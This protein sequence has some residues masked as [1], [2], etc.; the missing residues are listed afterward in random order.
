MCTFDSS[1]AQGAVA[2]CI[3]SHFENPDDTTRFVFATSVVRSSWVDWA[4]EHVSQAVPLERFL[5]W[6]EFKKEQLHLVEEEGQTI[7]SLLRKIFVQN[8]LA[9]G[10][11]VTGGASVKIGS[12]GAAGGASLTGAAKSSLFPSL[13]PAEVAG[14]PSQA[15]AFSD[16]IA[17]MLP[18]LKLWH[19]KWERAKKADPSLVADESD[20][21]YEKLY[22]L[23]KDFLAG[24]GR[25]GPVFYESAWVDSGKLAEALDGIE[26]DYIIIYPEI[27]DDWDEYRPFIE[28]SSRV[29]A[30]YLPGPDDMSERMLH[31]PVDFYTNARSELRACAVEIRRLCA[32]GDA[33][34]GDASVTGGEDSLP[35][36]AAGLVPWNQIAVSV[37]DLEKWRPYIEREFKLYCIPHVI[38]SAEKLT[39]GA[40]RIFREIQACVSENFS[41]ES[42]RA[43]LLDESLPWKDKQR[44]MFLIRDAL[45][46]KCL[47]NISP[48]G[49]DIWEKSLAAVNT[50]N[51]TEAELRLYVSLKKSLTAMCRAKSF[52]D[53]Y[54]GWFKFK[55]E[56]LDDSSFSPVD[57][58]RISRCISVLDELKTLEEQ[59]L[60]PLGLSSGDV[61]SFFLREVE[62]TVYQPQVQTDGVSVFDYKVAAASAYPFQFV[63]NLTQS[64]VAIPSASLSFL[65]AAKRRSLGL[66]AS[67]LSSD[68][69]IRL[70]GSDSH[71]RLSVSEETFSGFAI[72]YSL[73]AVAGKPRAFEIPDDDF[74]LQLRQTLLEEG[75]DSGARQAGGAAPGAVI[76]DL[77]KKGF[78]RWKESAQKTSDQDYAV[79]ERGK[80][81]ILKAVHVLPA[82][83]GD[84]R[85]QDGVVAVTQSDL[86]NAVVCMRRWLFNRVLSIEEES[87]DTDLLERFDVGNIN[88]KILELFM[89]WCR[90]EKG[91]RLP[92]FDG[93]SLRFSQVVE[94]AA[95][96]ERDSSAPDAEGSPHAGDSSLPGG[97]APEKADAACVGADDSSSEIFQKLLAFTE[98]TIKDPCQNFSA[99]P[100]AKDMLLAQKA[101][102]ARTVENFLN[103]L[104]KA[105][106]FGGS[107]VLGQELY[108]SQK[109]EHPDG[110][111]FSYFGGIDLMLR[112]T[113][114]MDSVV[115][116]KNTK[117][118]IPSLKDCVAENSAD[119]KNF[120]MLLYAKLWNGKGQ[121]NQLEKAVFTS[122]SDCN[123]SNVRNPTSTSRTLAN[124]DQLFD[125]DLD[126][127]DHEVTI[128]FVEKVLNFDLKPDAATVT[129]FKDC[130]GCSYRAICR[131]TYTVA[132]EK[133]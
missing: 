36:G 57:D 9:G 78:D 2:S 14:N 101:A 3:S 69:F 128:P 132:G 88:H 108:L 90:D 80:E 107:Q 64:D 77:Q 50:G 91:G 48:D 96:E 39:V 15:V 33:P 20:R 28:K 72:P 63:L 68:A 25:K 44:N 65:S 27:L 30:L 32:I 55:A 133:L 76:S 120:Q 17:S 5:A 89:Q 119:L 81:T 106:F 93:K 99:S 58:L 61:Y 103:F 66:S 112:D 98:Q 67:S 95:P 53:L 121:G 129:P 56:F 26:N 49:K 110:P 60:V 43:L 31:P 18:S 6:D 92:V 97:P 10:A 86:K 94:G 73:L 41:Y 114:G 4:C 111:A 47:C 38:R 1:S 12:G 45:A 34:A 118:S 113:E 8:L 52:D 24:K 51:T 62:N 13:I 85:S 83:E 124:R 46:A 127:M 23:Y 125:A 131:T 116:F 54:A 117:S 19:E 37:P 79:S 123:H 70:Y 59:Y 29:K 16:W 87:L 126:S 115:D 22:Q 104:C 75:Q 71:A 11:A 122:I 40:G 82:Y 100:L 109:V 42:V 21:D 102:F 105:D 84:K 130:E 35:S 7:P 74:V